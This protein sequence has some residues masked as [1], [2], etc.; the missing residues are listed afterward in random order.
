MGKAT[1]KSSAD[2]GSSKRMVENPLLTD[3]QFLALLDIK[4]ADEMPGLIEVDMNMTTLIGGF[5]RVKGRSEAQTLAAAR[6]RGLYERSRIGGARAMD[7]SAVRVD[8]SGPS[9]E[10]VFE[11]GDRARR[12]YISA[13]QFIG[14][15][16]SN[17]VERVVC[18]EMSI[19]DLAR[20]LGEGQGGAA[21]ERIRTQLCRSIDLL[22]THFGYA[23]SAPGGARMRADGDR[24]A[25]FT[26][27]VSTRRRAT[28]AA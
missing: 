3:A 12:E 20:M 14:M 2:G 21:F 7:Y 8:T 27:V 25:L 10:A 19:R 28:A 11:I 9:Q 18:D 22:V 16:N 26:G 17:L 1:R 13:V 4:A 24:P 5:A 6:F 23:G 15:I